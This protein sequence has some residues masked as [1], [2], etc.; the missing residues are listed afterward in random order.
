MFLRGALCTL[1]ISAMGSFALAIEKPSAGKAKATQQPKKP[2][3]RLV[4]PGGARPRAIA[5]K[6]RAYVQTPQ[7]DLVLEGPRD[8]KLYPGVHDWEFWCTFD[9]KNRG[10]RIAGTSLVRVDGTGCQDRTE[11]VPQLPAGISWSF[12]ADAWTKCNILTVD[13]LNQVA[14]SNENNNVYM[15][16]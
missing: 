3:L 5:A 15:I 16:E 4:Q 2:T 9:V 6:P 12:G 8:C 13:A 10:T 1:L 7:P 11:K 14:E